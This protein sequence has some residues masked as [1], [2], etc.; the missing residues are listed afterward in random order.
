[1]RLRPRKVL[2][3]ACQSICNE[4]NES[5]GSSKVP[6]TESQSKN[7]SV[8]KNQIQVIDNKIQ[9]MLPHISEHSN[10]CAQ[11]EVVEKNNR[12]T[13]RSSNCARESRRSSAC[14]THPPAPNRSKRKCSES[15]VSSLV[16]KI[17][18]LKPIDIEKASNSVSVV[19]ESNSICQPNDLSSSISEAINKDGKQEK[20]KL[21][22]IVKKDARELTSHSKKVCNIEKVKPISSELQIYSN[23]ECT[24]TTTEKIPKLRLSA[25]S[26]K[27]VVSKK[28][29]KAG[30]A[31]S[32]VENTSPK[33]GGLASRTRSMASVT[34]TECANKLLAIPK[35]VL[36][37]FSN[38]TDTT[39]VSKHY[40]SEFK[41]KIKTNDRD[42][43]LKSNLCRSKSIENSALNISP[44]PQK[45]EL[46]SPVPK[47]TI[48][49]FGQRKH[50]PT[51]TTQ[52]TNLKVAIPSKDAADASNKPHTTLLKICI[53]PDGTGKIMNISPKPGQSLAEVPEN[54]AEDDVQRRAKANVAA[55]AAKRA[56]KKAKKEAQRK[57]MLG[58]ASP[59]YALF[60]GVSPRFGGMSPMRLGGMSPA[61]LY[62]V[63]PGRF[64]GT[65]PGRFSGAS[66]GRFSGVSPARFSGAPF[67]SGGLINN[68]ALSPVNAPLDLSIKDNNCNATLLPIKKHKHK[69][70]HK[71]KHK[72]E[73]RHKQIDK[74]DQ[75]SKENLTENMTATK[76]P[77]T[78]S[79][80]NICDVSSN[81]S[82]D[83]RHCN[84]LVIL[85][86]SETACVVKTVTGSSSS[87]SS[88]VETRSRTSSPVAPG[89]QKLSLS[90]KRVNNESNEYIACDSN[91]SENASLLENNEKE[92]LN[93]GKNFTHFTSV[94]E[95]LRKACTSKQQNA[96][97][98]LKNTSISG[99]K[100]VHYGNKCCLIDTDPVSSDD[101]SD[102]PDF[103]SVTE[104]GRV[105]GE[106]SLKFRW[107]DISQCS[108]Q[109]LYS[110]SL[111]QLQQQQ[112]Q[113]LL[114]IDGTLKRRNSGTSAENTS[115]IISKDEVLVSSVTTDCGI[116]VAP[117]LAAAAVDVAASVVAFASSGVAASGGSGGD[118]GAAS[119]GN[120]IEGRHLISVGDVVWGKI[121]GFPWWPAKVSC[122]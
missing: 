45:R 51:E 5:V 99:K 47:L 34:E 113:Q 31:V 117:V 110:Q 112:Q 53:A 48:L 22:G 16:P 13:R 69:V 98:T 61:R 108:I 52:N 66:P 96:K 114:Q 83:E 14:A 7:S 82:S 25:S 89:R 62:G 9:D 76:L 41:K 77:I 92:G 93:V 29:P 19:K 65:S 116:S 55:K 33:G 11:T 115:P 2:C 26:L 67:A 54:E 3:S 101:Q 121:H 119:P 102:V 91:S 35:M 118:G 68:G 71:K 109:P 23:L 81:E 107:R 32:K 57:S 73:R 80:S 8:A 6:K 15:S 79:N 12:E 97:E 100:V 59:S 39:D 24:K 64:G 87:V 75:S 30:I 63:S 90:I 106:L 95:T 36:S 46:L 20:V 104:S 122:S 18:K 103:P 21:K 85:K 1:M 28:L 120:C 58:G 74:T 4:K 60:G 86:Q 105:L 88:I 44:I 42:Q 84:S 10:K 50:L 49:P 17:K 56:L 72:E 40:I 78:A 70:K 37:T 94:S 111:R 38:T 43:K 27:N